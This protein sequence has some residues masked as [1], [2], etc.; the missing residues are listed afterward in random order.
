L[1]SVHGDESKHPGFPDGRVLHHEEDSASTREVGVGGVDGPLNRHPLLPPGL[2]LG[3]GLHEGGDRR[4]M[5][6]SLLGDGEVM[7]QSRFAEEHIE[8]R[9][10]ADAMHFVGGD[11][12]D[13]LGQ[14][15]SQF[16]LV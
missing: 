15:M 8:H 16:P 12:Y 6:R 14:Q 3:L 9:E 11:E 10:S 7:G 4:S 13:G 2:G 5:G 1:G